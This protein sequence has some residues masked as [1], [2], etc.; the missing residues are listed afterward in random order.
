MK[1]L[2]VSCVSIAIVAVGLVA[3][4]AASTSSAPQRR[5][6]GQHAVFVQT[7]ELNGNRILDKFGVITGLPVGQEG[8]A[9]K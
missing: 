9:A 4:Q 2:V 8:I 6:G 5:H 1:R 7:N 3:A